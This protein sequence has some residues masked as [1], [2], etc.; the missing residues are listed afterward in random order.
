MSTLKVNTLEEAT[1]GGAT[2]FT[3]KT[4]VNF[5]GTGT[6]AIR[7]SGNVDGITDN[8]TG[9]Y[10]VGIDNTLSSGSYAA[11]TTSPGLS[12]TNQAYNSVILGNHNTGAY[13]KTSSDLRVALGYSGSSGMADTI[14]MNVS[15][16][17]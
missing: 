11:H 5:N 9:D 12:T 7:D 8:G 6:V 15:L 16:I 13:T 4:W 2:Y 10:T 14:D 17:L 1:S 3:A